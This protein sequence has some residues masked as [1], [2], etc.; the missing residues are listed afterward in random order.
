MTTFEKYVAWGLCPIPVIKGS[1]QPACDWKKYQSS[2]PSAVELK[3]WNDDEFNIGVVC[4][5]VSNVVVLDV[6]SPEAQD[7]IDRLDLPRTPVAVTA[8]GKHY[9]F[10]SP[11]TEIRNSV[12]V[13]G[14]KLDVR[15][16]G[17]FVVAPPSIHESGFRYE[18]EVSP[19]DAPFAPMPDNLL[20]LLKSSPGRALQTHSRR[21]VVQGVIVGSRFDGV[22][23][24]HLND[25]L[26]E[27]RLAKDGERNDT[28]N[29]VAFGLARIAAP[30][31]AD[32]DFLSAEMLQCALAI[33]LS[34]AESQST[35]ASALKAGSAEPAGW[36][37]AA[38]NW[39]Y[40]S[41]PDQFIHISTKRRLNQTAFNRTFNAEMPGLKGSIGAYL[42]DN[43]LIEKVYDFRLNPKEPAIYDHDGFR[44]LNTYVPPQI[45]PVEGDAGPFEDFMRYLVP[46][47]I[48]RDHLIAWLAYAVR[49]PGDK[50]GHA[51]M[52]RSSTQGIG[53]T[54]L[55]NIFRRLIGEENTRKASSDELRGAFQSFLGD[56]LLVVFEETNLGA[57]HSTYNRLK[58]MISDDSVVINEK[59]V[60]AREAPN[61]A[62]FVFLSN[63]ETPLLLGENDRRFF[64][65][66][67]T[68]SPREPDYYRSLSEWWPLSL[69]IIRNWLDQIDLSTF[70]PRGRPPQTVSHA[71]LQGRSR[72]LLQQELLSLFQAREGPFTRDIF[73][74]EEVH[75]ALPSY[76]RVRTT[77]QIT[78]ALRALG[79]ADIG[80]HRTKDHGGIV[81]GSDT[82]EKVRERE[83]VYG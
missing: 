28:L 66:L 12:R 54:T 76:V 18:W 44:W 68:A 38:T 63:L 72:N 33:G 73:A 61:L 48:E 31:G 65:I 74:I 71:N 36:V 35:L 52:L 8:R 9:Y 58:D 46:N 45:E 30:A 69:G 1:K 13:Q 29:R 77:G 55:T 3:K 19:D 47:D 24:K 40:A 79:A 81:R 34:E 26:D 82:G 5:S 53:K 15:A 75:W 39:V 49:N 6:D 20:A 32:L 25:A 7:F 17:G 56:K 70:E 41:N 22:L 59:Y 80:Q 50:I 60:P 2:L 16:E 23:E 67:S 11:N 37:V 64:D 83:R 21:A 42:T 43:D 57:G 10:A 4:G 14:L 27:L 62:N 78:E 51:V